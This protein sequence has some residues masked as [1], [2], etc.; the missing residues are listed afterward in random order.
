MDLRHTNTILTDRLIDR[1]KSLDAD[2]EIQVL[3]AENLFQFSSRCYPSIYIYIETSSRFSS[4]DGPFHKP[5][6]DLSC[7]PRL[8][9]CLRV[10]IIHY[11]CL[12]LCIYIVYV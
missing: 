3:S 1:H 5:I 10:C 6:L 2:A 9:V 4:L 12:C 7:D 8:C 11:V